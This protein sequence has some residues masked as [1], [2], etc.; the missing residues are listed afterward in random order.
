M[1]KPIRFFRKSDDY[2]QPTNFYPHGFTEDGKYW[3]TVE[4]YY[5][6]MKFPKDRNAKH[7]E[8]IRT[9]HSPGQA[10]ALGRTG[11]IAIRSDWEAVKED[12]KL[13]A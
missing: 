5:Q 11:N 10:K 12:F 7:I 6:A 4:H 2:S 8:R 9:A 1:A 3:Q 13:H